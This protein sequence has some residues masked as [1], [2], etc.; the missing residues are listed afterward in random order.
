MTIELPDGTI[1]EAEQ[2][3]GVTS[4]ANSNWQFF[5]AGA[6]QAFVTV[7]FGPDGNLESFEDNTIAQE[8]FGDT[9][10]FD[11]QRH[12]TAQQGLQYAAATYGAETDDATSFAFE[13]RLSVFFAGIKAATATATATA[14]YDPDDHDTVEGTFTFSVNVTIPQIPDIPDDEFDFV[15]RRVP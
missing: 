7:T 8:I 6:T 11:G 5:R 12:S 2:G 4:L 1:I 10:Q 13:G 15:G 3:D 14:T 9:I